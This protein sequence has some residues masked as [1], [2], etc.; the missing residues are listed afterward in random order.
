MGVF[1][2]FC[3]QRQFRQRLEKSRPRLYR[4]AYAWCGDASLADDLTQETM[5]RALERRRQLRELEAMPKWL[6]VILNNLWRDHLRRFVPLASIDDYEFVCERTPE[7]DFNQ[8]QTTQRVRD[9]VARLPLGQREVLTLVE[10]EGLRYREVAEVLNIPIG[11]VMSRLNR[12]RQTLK[13]ELMEGREEA[14]RTV[15]LKRVV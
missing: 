12:A 7:I 2:K 15:V 3:G 10:L 11:T 4:L 6:A 13:D 14:S 1:E 5:A 8:E 9:S